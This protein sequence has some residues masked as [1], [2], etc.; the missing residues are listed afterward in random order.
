[1]VAVSGTTCGGVGSRKGSGGLSQLQVSATISDMRDQGRCS[2]SACDL[3]VSHCHAK[4]DASVAML[5]S[6]LEYA[7]RQKGN[8]GNN[9]PG[10]LSDTTMARHINRIFNKGI[11]A[12]SFTVCMYDPLA[13]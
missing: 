6:V 2:T 9:L 5:L 10:L 1:M 11:K 13:H 7:T 12:L 3:G 4:G 8:M